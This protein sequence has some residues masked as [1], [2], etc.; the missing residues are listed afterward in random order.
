MIETYKS[1]K[2]KN[3]EIQKEPKKKDSKNRRRKRHSQKEAKKDKNNEIQVNDRKSQ[4]R[5]TAKTEGVKGIAKKETKKDKHNA[6]QVMKFV[7]DFIHFRIQFTYRKYTSGCPTYNLQLERYNGQILHED[8]KVLSVSVD[9]SGKTVFTEQYKPVIRALDLVKKSGFNIGVESRL[10]PDHS[11]LKWSIEIGPI[12]P[13][14]PSD[15]TVPQIQIEKFDVK[16]IPTDFLITGEVQ[17]QLDEAIST[18][19]MQQHA[20]GDID[21][22]YQIFLNTIK[23]EMNNKLTSKTYT[24]FSGSVNKRKRIK[25]AWWTDNLTQLWNEMCVA[26][27]KWNK[28]KDRDKKFLK[29]VFVQKRKDFDKEVQKSKRRYWYKLQSNLIVEMNKDSGNFWKK[30]GKVGISSERKNLIPIE[31]VNSDG[32]VEYEPD[33]V[34]DRWKTDF[35]NLLNRPTEIVQNST[36]TIPHVQKLDF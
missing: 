23:R 9:A 3:N 33:T 29:T 26:E 19:E 7:Y 6:I 32:V 30:I 20:Q 27:S 17:S 16:E 34:L 31:V 35:E 21:N 2:D 24:M 25:K 1:K 11:L 4:R 18:L 28:S 8:V 14:I 22:S 12:L 13:S 36:D 15:V 10:V 5:K